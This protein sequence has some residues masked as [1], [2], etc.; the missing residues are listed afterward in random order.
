MRGFTVNTTA[1]PLKA[2]PRSAKPSSSQVVSV[3]PTQL[4]FKI[5]PS[6]CCPKGCVFPHRDL[7][8]TR[9]IST[10]SRG[11]RGLTYKFLSLPFGLSLEPRTFMQ[12][13]AAILAPLGPHMC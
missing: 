4:N 7:S 10:V 11:S 12:C 2:T 6:P 9:E 13:V 1:L 3:R 8:S 5:P